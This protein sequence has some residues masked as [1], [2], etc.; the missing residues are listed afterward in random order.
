MNDDRA[1]IIAKVRGWINPKLQIE[2]VSN[3]DLSPND[4]VIHV[5]GKTDA[6]YFGYQSDVQYF[7]AFPSDSDSLSISTYFYFEQSDATGFTVLPHEYKTIFANEM[8]IP[9]LTLGLWYTWIP[10]LKN[11]KSLQMQKVIWFD[12]FS[13]NTFNDGLSRVLNG[14]EIVSAKYEQFRDSIHRQK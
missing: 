6:D 9:L 5:K 11:I 2:D 13:K 1:T 4:V 10:D 7:I 3:P 12:G 14:Y 8:K